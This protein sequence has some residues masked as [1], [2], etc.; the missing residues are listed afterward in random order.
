MRKHESLD[1]RLLDVIRRES[2]SVTIR[3]DVGGARKVLRAFAALA[4][5]TVSTEQYNELMDVSYSAEDGV[6]G[7]FKENIHQKQKTG[8][9]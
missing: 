4:Q 5:P 7:A 9:V 2:R 6:F 3:K 8:Q 1:E